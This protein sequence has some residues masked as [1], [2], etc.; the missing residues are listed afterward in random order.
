ME[1]IVP[2]FAYI[3]DAVQVLLLNCLQVGVFSEVLFGDGSELVVEQCEMLVEGEIELL[4]FLLLDR[5]LA[6]L[7][8]SRLHCQS[9][10][11]RLLPPHDRRVQKL[12]VD[13]R[14]CQ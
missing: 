6:L 5:L 8:L 4:Q 10:F 14:N 3:L 9:P 7:L 1:Q 11:V 12:V 13:T 2:P